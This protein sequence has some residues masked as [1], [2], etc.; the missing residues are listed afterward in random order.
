MLR[1][2]SHEITAKKS[3]LEFSNALYMYSIDLYL[4]KNNL[5]KMQFCYDCT[6]Y[7]R[8]V[9]YVMMRQ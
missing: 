2:T 6:F 9:Q 8:N 4:D 7:Y 3:I 1:T 5:L